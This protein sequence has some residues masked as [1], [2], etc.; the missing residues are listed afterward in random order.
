MNRN[1]MI[2]SKVYDVCG[3]IHMGSNW[4]EEGVATAIQSDCEIENQSEPKLHLM[5]LFSELL[6]FKKDSTN[7]LACL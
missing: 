6:C 5:L 2:V 1:V 7:S 3:Y 4:L